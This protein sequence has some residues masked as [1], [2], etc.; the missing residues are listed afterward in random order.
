[1]CEEVSAGENRKLLFLLRNI[2]ILIKREVENSDARKELDNVTGTHGYVI[3]YLMGRD[4]EDVFQ[5][6]IE[7]RFSIRRS[8]VTEILN[9]MQ[10]N[11]LINRSAVE[12]DARLKKITLTD[13]ARNLFKVVEKDRSEFEASVFEGFSSD[14][15]AALSGY[16]ERITENLKKRT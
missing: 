13:K 5:R 8:T 15:I 10:K 9:L 6:D 11:G 4:G 12:S 16:L 2:Y 3:C 14:E 7:K 1:M